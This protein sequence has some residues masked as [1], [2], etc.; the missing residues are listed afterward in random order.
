LTG[1]RFFVVSTFLAFLTATLLG[2]WTIQTLL[3]RQQVNQLTADLQAIV[4]AARVATDRISTDDRIHALR[5]Q[6]AQLHVQLDEHIATRAGLA[7]QALAATDA[8][9]VGEIL[10]QLREVIQQ[11]RQTQAAAQDALLD[12][13]DQ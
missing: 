6:L 9:A 1:S 12:L 10:E 5:R 8:A 7:D 4:G 11:S 13:T 2:V 3:Y